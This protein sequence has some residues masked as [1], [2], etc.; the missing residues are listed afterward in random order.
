MACSC[1]ESCVSY[2]DRLGT[3]DEGEVGMW[4]CGA[5]LYNRMLEQA[6]HSDVGTH[7]DYSSAAG[8]FAC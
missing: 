6:A 8:R 1:E 4:R 2:H 5:D 3:G 7:L